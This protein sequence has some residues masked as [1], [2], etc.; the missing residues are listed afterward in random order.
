MQYSVVHLAYSFSEEWEQDLFEQSLCDIGFEVFD[1]ANAYIQT[2]VLEE[3]KEALEGLI[4]ETEGV[5]L[6]EIEQCEDINWNA[7]WE[8]EHEI[9][10]LPLGVRITPHCAFGAGHHE[11]VVTAGKY[12]KF[13]IAANDIDR[14]IEIAKEYDMRI[15]GISQHVGSLF[16]EPELF[17]QAVNNLL[18]FATK[19]EKLDFIDFG[20]GYGIPY[21]KLSGQAEFDMDALAS[22]FDDILDDIDLALKCINKCLFNLLKRCGIFLFCIFKE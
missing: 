20:G 8:A 17:L 22:K 7:T 5:E 1:N 2:S 16:M 15:V 19:F 9:V 10:E 21:Q 11:K 12:T 3:N 18:A 13:A 4:A 6:I 14:A